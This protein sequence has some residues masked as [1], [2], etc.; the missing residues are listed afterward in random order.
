MRLISPD[1]TPLCNKYLAAINAFSASF[2]EPSEDIMQRA[3]F[4]GLANAL[5]D[6]HSEANDEQ[7]MHS[8]N[9][10][11]HEPLDLLIPFYV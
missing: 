8:Q 11:C 7:N 1:D 5:R 3:L 6:G 4:R 9:T 2:T 10:W